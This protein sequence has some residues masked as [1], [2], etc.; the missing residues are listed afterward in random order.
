MER[1]HPL[2]VTLHWLT[3]ILIIVTLLSG[4]IA[5][6]D[7]HLASG[8]LVFLLFLLRVVARLKAQNPHLPTGNGGLQSRLARLMHLALYGLIFGVAVSGIGVAVETDLFQVMQGA[9][10]WPANFAASA[11]YAAHTLLTKLLLGAVAAHVIAALWH[12]IV[13][14]DGVF[15]RMWFTKPSQRHQSL[16]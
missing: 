14:R 15:S 2:L 7:F 8:V 13:M 5:P 11:M 4:G 6:L 16:N 1:H 10:Q 3:A 12:L 9:G